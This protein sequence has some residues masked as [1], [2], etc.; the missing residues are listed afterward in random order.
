MIEDFTIKPQCQYWH[1][2]THRSTE[3][4][5]SSQISSYTYDQ[6]NFKNKTLLVIF[7]YVYV[8]LWVYTE[9][10]AREGQNKGITFSGSRGPGV[11]ESPD[12]SAGN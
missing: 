6:Y 3:Q 9:C 7:S 1:A 11:C 8:S 4:N 12:V 10:G 2:E 5:N